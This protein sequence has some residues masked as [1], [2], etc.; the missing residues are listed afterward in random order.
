LIECH[1]I[2]NNAL[3]LLYKIQHILYINIENQR[4][5]VIHFVLLLVQYH[6]SSNNKFIF[7]VTLDLIFYD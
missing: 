3:N 6:M 5:A 7:F 2:V 1:S 4:L